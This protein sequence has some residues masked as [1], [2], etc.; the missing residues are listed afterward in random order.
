LLSYEAEAEELKADAVVKRV[1]DG[2]PVP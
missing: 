2:L 1:L